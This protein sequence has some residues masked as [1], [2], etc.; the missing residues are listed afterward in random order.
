MADPKY[1]NLSG[2][3][4]DQP[5]VY[6]TDDLPEAD[7]G[8]QLLEEKGDTSEHI[9]QLHIDAKQATLK[10]KDKTINVN[11]ADFSD[12]LNKLHKYGYDVLSQDWELVAKGEKE[13]P[14]QKYQRLQCELKELMDEVSQIKEPSEKIDGEKSKLTVE[15]IEQLVSQV[16]AIKLDKILGPDLLESLSDVEGAALKTLVMRLDSFAVF[17]A[18][19]T[20]AS[21]DK[22]SAGDLV[23]YQLGL[24]S[25]QAQLNTAAKLTGLEQ[26]LIKLENML[27][28]HSSSVCKLFGGGH[29][30]LI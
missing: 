26:R 19:T 13:T 11:R 23:R 12:S 22:G 15:Q 29:N 27:G 21:K 25:Q 4:Y 8:S 7:Q 30:S 10:F 17:N 1:A 14:L 20:P 9:E 2:I 18:K 24:Q 16:S 5:D 28:E 6:E 3:A